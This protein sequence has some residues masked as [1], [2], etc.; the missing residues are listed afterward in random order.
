MSFVDSTRFVV[1]LS[2]CGRTLWKDYVTSPVGPETSGATG[3]K[4]AE[5]SAVILLRAGAEYSA[6]ETFTDA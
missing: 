5:D 1:E 6:A 4:D 2:G 3:A